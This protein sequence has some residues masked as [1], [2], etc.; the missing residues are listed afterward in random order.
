MAALVLVAALALAI[1]PARAAVDE[2]ETLVVRVFDT[3]GLTEGEIATMQRIAD[4]ALEPAGL[5]I[6]WKRC[7]DTALWDCAPG[8]GRDL[9]VRIV[10]RHGAGGG[11]SCGFAMVESDRGFVSL[12]RTCAD[13]T[14]ASL[15]R[16]WMPLDLQPLATDEV[17]GYMLAHEIAHILLPR[18]GHS[19]NGLFKARIN[20]RDWRMARRGG[21]TFSRADIERLREAASAPLVAGPAAAPS[22]SLTEVL[23]SR[24]PPR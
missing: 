2:R 12:S 7:L 14:V 15:E 21:L 6:R 16:K 5:P 8:H 1:D 19:R 13:R 23:Q 3:V 11:G 9:I 22:H 17:L 24:H 10:E 4:D 18:T 20:A